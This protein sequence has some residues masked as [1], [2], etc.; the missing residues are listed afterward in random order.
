MKRFLFLILLAGTG[1]RLRANKRDAGS[2]IKWV[3]HFSIH[4]LYCCSSGTAVASIAAMVEG[5]IQ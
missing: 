1:V 5:V 4:L 3:I 2:K